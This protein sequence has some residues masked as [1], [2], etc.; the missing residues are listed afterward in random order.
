[1]VGISVEIVVWVLVVKGI[2]IDARLGVIAVIVTMTLTNSSTNVNK[3]RHVEQNTAF[4]TIQ[5][6]VTFLFRLERLKSETNT[7]S[8]EQMEVIRHLTLQNETN[9][10]TFKVRSSFWFGFSCLLKVER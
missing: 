3:E 7:S 8:D 4:V 2:V 9:S 10:A 5:Y 1:M 6:L